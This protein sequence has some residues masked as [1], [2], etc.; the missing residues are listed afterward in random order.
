MSYLKQPYH[1]A[2]HDGVT[3][4]IAPREQRD[5]G[6]IMVTVTRQVWRGDGYKPERIW[7]GGFSDFQKM[8]EGIQKRF[9]GA[10]VKGRVETGSGGDPAYNARESIAA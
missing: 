7:H 4:E 1:D 6:P 10:T 3:Y 2:K 5:G 9:P 8:S